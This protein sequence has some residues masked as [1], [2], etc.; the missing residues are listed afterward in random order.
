M[1]ASSAHANPGGGW[2]LPRAHLR[3]ES[4]PMGTVLALLGRKLPLLTAIVTK[5]D[6]VLKS[7]LETPN[8]ALAQFF[9]TARTTPRLEDGSQGA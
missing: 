2:K 6:I 1:S 4:W 5:Y 9:R 7:L 8:H 3:L